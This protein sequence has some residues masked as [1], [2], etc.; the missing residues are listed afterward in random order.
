MSQELVSWG[1]HWFN[2]GVCHPGV[3]S[4]GIVR[5]ENSAVIQVDLIQQDSISIGVIVPTA[6]NSV[7]YD[8]TDP[9]GNGTF[10]F[11]GGCLTE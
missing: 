3:I 1:V 8:D 6:R 4:G 5:D 7:P 11:P 10:H 9:Y 2:N